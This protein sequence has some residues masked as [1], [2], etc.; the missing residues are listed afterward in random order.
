M[1]MPRLPAKMRGLVARDAISDQCSTFAAKVA[2]ASLMQHMVASSLGGDVR[3][4]QIAALTINPRKRGFCAP[5]IGSRDDGGIAG[6]FPLWNGGGCGVSAKDGDTG[7]GDS[8]RAMMMLRAQLKEVIPV[9]RKSI[10][11]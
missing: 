1:L 6:S 9:K 10:D 8:A 4:D 5:I 11:S 7:A 2:L 3:A